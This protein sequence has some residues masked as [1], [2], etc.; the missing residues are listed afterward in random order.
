MGLLGWRRSWR[1]TITRIGNW[2]LALLVE[3]EYQDGKR[4][5]GT[6]KEH[7]PDGTVWK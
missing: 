7:K 2:Q 1:I 4:V 3:R 5:M 6:G